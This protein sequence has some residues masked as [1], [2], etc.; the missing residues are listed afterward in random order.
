MLNFSSVSE[1]DDGVDLVAMSSAVNARRHRNCF[2]GSRKKDSNIFTTMMT[3]F[4]GSP[5]LRRNDSNHSSSSYADSPPKLECSVTHDVTMD[6]QDP[7]NNGVNA[8]FKELSP[9]QKET[10][11]GGCCFGKKPAENSSKDEFTPRSSKVK[12]DPKDGANF[13]NLDQEM[14]KLRPMVLSR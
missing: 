7:C 2:S 6:N 13:C 14:S 5:T 10:T 9:A 11:G 3:E 4:F 8:A 1:K 12:S